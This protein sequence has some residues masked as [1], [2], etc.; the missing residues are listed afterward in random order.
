MN[1]PLRPYFPFGVQY[2]GFR[3]GAC[4]LGGRKILY[5]LRNIIAF[6]IAEDFHRCC[7]CFRLAAIF[8]KKK[9]ILN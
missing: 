4:G 2:G 1:L 7:L 3:S 9:K 5:S 8:K 6:L